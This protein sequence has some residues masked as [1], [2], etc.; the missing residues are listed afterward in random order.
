MSSAAPDPSAEREL[1]RACAEG[2]ALDL[3]GR[4]V[5]A[6]ALKSLLLS[7]DGNV[8]ELSGAHITGALAL[9]GTEIRQ[10]L[11]LHSCEFDGP[12]TLEAASTLAVSI[13]DSRIPGFQAPTARIGG[14]LDLRGSTIDGRGLSAVKLVH[15]HIAGGLRLD[16]AKLIAPGLVALDAGGLVME[17][18]VFCED[19]FTAEGQVLFP[20]AQLPGGLFMRGARIAIDAPDDIA[21]NGDNV[22]ASTVR[23]SKGFRAAGKVRVRGA[24]IADLLSFHDAELL[25][26]GTALLCIG[27]RADAFDLRFAQ[28]PQGVVDLRNAYASRI[29]D[30]PA[31]WPATLRLDGLVYEWLETTAARGRD[32]VTNRL[33]WLRHNPGY[34]PQ[35][36]EQLANNYRRLGHDADARRVLLARQRRRRATLGPAGR[37]WGCLLDATVGYGYR[38]W[39]AGVWLTLLTLLGAAVFATF[40]PTADRPGEGPPFNPFVYALDLLLPIG[41]LGQGSAWHWENGGVQALAYTLTAIG[42]ILTTTV[43]AGMSRTLSKN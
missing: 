34:A 40:T 27:T 17:G 21:F 31:T 1:E 20:G 32:D 25:G 16:A 23:L 29:Q 8:L 19:G 14:R 24:Q 5:R 13:T 35:P 12:V 30:H 38:T 36:Y 28:A 15:T 39:I 10:L 42:W 43:V 3:G 6:G 33:T 26:E 18:G 22:T 37:A 41:G 2:Q 9:D 7:G 11:R 4:V